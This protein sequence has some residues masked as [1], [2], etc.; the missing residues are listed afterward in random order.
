ML[1]LGAYFIC[2]PDR[3]IEIACVKTNDRM[4]IE[5]PL[6]VRWNHSV[7]IEVIGSR[8]KSLSLNSFKF[9]L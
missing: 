1:V 2:F 9:V 8:D 7:G 6:V 3:C 5:L 4:S